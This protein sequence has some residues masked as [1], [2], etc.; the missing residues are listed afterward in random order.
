MRTLVSERRCRMPYTSK[1]IFALFVWR[2]SWDLI[3]MIH[4]NRLWRLFKTCDVMTWSGDSPQLWPLYPVQMIDSNVC[5][6]GWAHQLK[7]FSISSVFSQ[8]F[9]LETMYNNSIMLLQLPKD[10]SANF[11]LCQ[12]LTTSGGRLRALKYILQFLKALNILLWFFLRISD[13]LLPELQKFSMH[14]LWA[15]NANI[16][17]CFCHFCFC[18]N[19]LSS[20]AR[21]GMITQYSV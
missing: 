8:S 18:V 10:G 2:V 7:C 12:Q 11:N 6:C 9:D 13:W 1:S 4:R 14:S 19:C 17:L 16:V 3:K 21:V 20:L 5:I 15:V